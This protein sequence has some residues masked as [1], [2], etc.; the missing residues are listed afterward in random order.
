M[1]DRALNGIIYKSYLKG[2]SVAIRLRCM[3]TTLQDILA[4]V[5]DRFRYRKG[6]SRT[7]SGSGN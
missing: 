4:S 5:I 1:L 2:C 3:L 6:V 7:K